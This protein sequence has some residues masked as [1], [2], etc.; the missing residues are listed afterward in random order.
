MLSS[1]CNKQNIPYCKGFFFKV[2]F[3]SLQIRQI[4]IMYLFKDNNLIIRNRLFSFT[5]H[6]STLVRSCCPGLGYF[7]LC[8]FVYRYRLTRADNSGKHELVENVMNYSLHSDRIRYGLPTTRPSH[9]PGSNPESIL[10]ILLLAQAAAEAISS[11]FMRT[12]DHQS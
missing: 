10:D 8:S 11:D 6:W 1:P 12:K 7:K 5:S 9:V 2:F 3:V 4:L